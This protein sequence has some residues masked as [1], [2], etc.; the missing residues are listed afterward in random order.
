M[1]IHVKNLTFDF[2]APTIPA[3]FESNGQVVAGWPA[4]HKVVDIVA[5]DTRR[6]WLIEVKDYRV[7][8]QPPKHANLG[9]LATT[10]DRKVRETLAALGHYAAVGADAALVA[11]AKTTLG[12]PKTRV[13][14]H[15]EPHPKGGPDSALFPKRFSA[16]ILQKLKQL[17]KGIDPRPLVLEIASTPSAGVPWSVT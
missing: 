2:V 7:I 13:V 4:G 3:Q 17:V 16:S 9:N 6:A 1:R 5:H 11:H 10:M 8:T 12:K 15:L 14:L